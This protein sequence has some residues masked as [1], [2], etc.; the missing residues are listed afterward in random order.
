MILTLFSQIYNV[1]DNVQDLRDELSMMHLF[2]KQKF[3][4]EKWRNKIV[5]VGRDEVGI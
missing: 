5:T 2:M 4:A 3:S 1:K